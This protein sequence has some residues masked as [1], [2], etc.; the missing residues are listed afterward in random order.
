[1]AT[2]TAGHHAV[3]AVSNVMCSRGVYCYTTTAADL[4]GESIKFRVTNIFS[5][6]KCARQFA[7]MRASS[8]VQCCRAR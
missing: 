7:L 2:G 8:T 3:V 6:L 4:S 1:M 5:E